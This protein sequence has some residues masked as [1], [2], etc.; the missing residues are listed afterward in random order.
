MVHK[1]NLF[2][3]KYKHALGVNWHVD[4]KEKDDN[5]D[6]DYFFHSVFEDYRICF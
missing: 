2:M 1:M 3:A 6:H 5:F 4:R